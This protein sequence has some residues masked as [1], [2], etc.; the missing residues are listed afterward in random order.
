M[1][2]EPNGP[3]RC[4]WAISVPCALPDHIMRMGQWSTCRTNH[5][6]HAKAHVRAGIADRPDGPWTVQGMV[7]RTTLVHGPGRTMRPRPPGHYSRTIWAGRRVDPVHAVHG[8]RAHRHRAGLPKRTWSKAMRIARRARDRCRIPDSRRAGSRPWTS[9]RSAGAGTRRAAMPGLRAAAGPEQTAAQQTH[10][11]NKTRHE[12]QHPDRRKSTTQKPETTK[13]EPRTHTASH[14]VRRHQ[15]T[16]EKAHPDAISEG[17]GLLAPT[18]L[19]RP[20]IGGAAT[21]VMVFAVRASDIGVRRY[22]RG[23][24]RGPGGGA[25]NDGNMIQEPPACPVCGLAVEERDPRRGKPLSIHRA[26]RNRRREEL[27]KERE[28]GRRMSQ[29]SLLMA[30]RNDVA[31]AAAELRRRVAWRNEAVGPADHGTVELCYW[32]VR[33]MAALMRLEPETLMAY[34]DRWAVDL[35]RSIGRKGMDRIAG[36]TGWRGPRPWTMDPAMSDTGEARTLEGMWPE[37]GPGVDDEWRADLD[38]DDGAGPRAVDMDRIIEGIW[39]EDHRGRN[40]VD[41]GWWSL[42]EGARP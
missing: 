8:P 31:E 41:H 9:P 4:M 19:R 7:P 15:K 25:M 17:D 38:H 21:F 14:K 24:R 36:L 40:G 11:R 29:E 28:R 34:E 26:C 33:C 20:P 30:S 32:S 5:A 2:R 12:N 6:A 23:G 3:R 18:A 10:T 13:T 42:D 27:R 37:P 1:G 39:A 35:A 16:Q 22:R